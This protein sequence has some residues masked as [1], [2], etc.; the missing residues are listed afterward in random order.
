M[1]KKRKKYTL[2]MHGLEPSVTGL[3]FDL[4]FT[5]KVEAIDKDCRN[6]DD[7]LFLIKVRLLCELIDARL[8]QDELER[9]KFKGLRSH[10]LIKA[11]LRMKHPKLVDFSKKRSKKITTKFGRVVRTNKVKKSRYKE[12]N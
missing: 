11:L 6:W 3:L 2:K 4:W 8:K 12:L 7:P 1:I 10:Y 9:I 5:V